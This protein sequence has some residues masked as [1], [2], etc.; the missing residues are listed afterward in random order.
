MREETP[1]K[2]AGT[3]SSIELDLNA[4]YEKSN[5]RETPLT[6]PIPTRIWSAGKNAETNVVDEQPSKQDTRWACSRHIFSSTPH[7]AAIYC[8]IP[9][10]ARAQN[11]CLRV[12][13]RPCPGHG[14]TKP[15]RQ[16][17]QAQCTA[18]PSV[19]PPV[20]AETEIPSFGH[21]L[22]FHKLG[23][24]VQEMFSHKRASR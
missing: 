10:S 24:E 14:S 2:N 3:L 23:I 13:A 1:R 6:T 11:G 5:M 16:Y 17:S 8:V 7:T 12:P 22:P 20:R 19:Q 18:S 21:H 15:G 4:S 9:P